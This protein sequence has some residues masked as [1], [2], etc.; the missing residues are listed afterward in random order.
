MKTWM[1]QVCR[2]VLSG[3]NK[4]KSFELDE[5]HLRILQELSDVAADP[6][7]IILE[8]SWKTREVLLDWKWPNVKF[9]SLKKKN[10]EN[11]IT[12]LSV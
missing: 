7:P 5:L 11:S 12:D 8:K 9:Q 6:L 10:K 1:A 3:L 4:F 2:L